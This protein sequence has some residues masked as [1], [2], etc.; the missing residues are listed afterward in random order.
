MRH[1]AG[2]LRLFASAT[3][4]MGVALPAQTAAQTGCEAKRRSCVAEC[5]A[6]YFTVDPKRN[7]CIAKCEA[8]ASRCVRE[9][10]ARQGG[11]TNLVFTRGISPTSHEAS[12][13]VGLA[14]L[15]GPGSLRV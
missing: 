5:R 6:Q 2:L 1:S 12:G 15:A 14:N 8:E 4:A 9:Q 3:L 10:A 13:V 11:A 7:A